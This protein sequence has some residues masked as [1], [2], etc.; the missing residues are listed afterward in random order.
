[1]SAEMLNKLLL[2]G[3]K[4]SQILTCPFGDPCPC[5]VKGPQKLCGLGQ[6]QMRQVSEEPKHVD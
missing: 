4:S 1:M 5:E 2:A 6:P 3:Y